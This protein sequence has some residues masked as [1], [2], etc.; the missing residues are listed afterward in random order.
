M[1]WLFFAGGILVLLTAILAVGHLWFHFVD[2]VL[3]RIKNRLFPPKPVNWH[4]LHENKTTQ[5]G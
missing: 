1:D 2:G 5:D 3:E 4:T